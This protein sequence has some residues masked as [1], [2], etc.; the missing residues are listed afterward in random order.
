MAKICPNCGATNRDN[1]TFCR[2]CGTNFP[3]QATKVSAPHQAPTRP[4]IPRVTPSRSRYPFYYPRWGDTRPNLYKIF[5]S[6]FLAGLIFTSFALLV[7]FYSRAPEITHSPIVSTFANRSI[8]LNATVISG[9]LG[10]HNV[11]VLYNSAKINAIKNI[12]MELVDNRQPYIATIPANDIDST[13][14]YSL[15]AIGGS[16]SKTYTPTYIVEVKDFNITLSDKELKVRIEEDESMTMDIWSLSNFNS[17]VTLSLSGLPSG[18][19]HNFSHD[20]LTPPRNG[21]SSSTLMI[22]PSSTANTG[23]F[24]VKVVGTFGNLTHSESII[25]EVI[26]EKDFDISANPTSIKIERGDI[27]IYNLTITPLN[28]FNDTVSISISGAPSAS[29]VTL[30]V[31]DNIINFGEAREI[32][33]QVK[34]SPTQFGTFTMEVTVTGGGKTK[35][36]DLSLQILFT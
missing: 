17:P 28:G 3:R 5:M 25:L 20:S 31:H 30:L 4:I 29:T 11:T 6:V 12:S 21:S 19:N 10:T 27:A 13:I 36:L 8:D 35:T 24:S 15:E 22:S 1:S 16:G 14:T 9:G 34:T 2:G 32:Y 26:P 7:N 23:T 18:I 33:L